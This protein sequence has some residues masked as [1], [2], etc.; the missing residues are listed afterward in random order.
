MNFTCLI[1]RLQA[2]SYN[3]P[4]LVGAFGIFLMIF[5]VLSVFVKG[6]AYIS[7]FSAGAACLYFAREQ[8]KDQGSFKGK[9]P[10]S[11]SGNEGSTPSP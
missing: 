11:E 7:M 3:S 9:T 10:D 4:Y 5:L 6:L 1:E 8:T 2:D